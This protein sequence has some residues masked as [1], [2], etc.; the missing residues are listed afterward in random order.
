VRAKYYEERE[1]PVLIMGAYWETVVE[2]MYVN[3]G[4]ERM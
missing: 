1:E 2:R 4:R 3:V